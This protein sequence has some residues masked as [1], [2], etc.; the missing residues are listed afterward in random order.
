MV[1]HVRRAQP[2]QLSKSRNPTTFKS[3]SCL[4]HKQRNQV[5]KT[6]CTTLRRLCFSREISTWLIIKILQ[7]PTKLLLFDAVDDAIENA[8]EIVECNR[9]AFG[10]HSSCSIDGWFRS[11]FSFAHFHCWLRCLFP[12]LR[13]PFKLFH[14]L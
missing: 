7:T 3:T 5:T 12:F 13:F 4:G 14:F 8:L 10:S 1:C 11:N 2:N 9:H 6:K